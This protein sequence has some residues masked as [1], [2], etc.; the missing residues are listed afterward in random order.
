MDL[1]R[2]LMHQRTIVLLS[3]VVHLLFCLEYLCS[4]CIVL[5]VF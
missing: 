4:S 3:A 2:E 1:S 5:K